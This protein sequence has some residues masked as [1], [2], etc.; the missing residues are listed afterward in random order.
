MILFKKGCDIGLWFVF[1][2]LICYEEGYK[3]TVES[4]LLHVV[5]SGSWKFLF[6]W[7]L[8]VWSMD[9]LLVLKL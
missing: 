1:I 8:F 3:Y 2:D 5:L 6:Q 9:V 4:F 7:K